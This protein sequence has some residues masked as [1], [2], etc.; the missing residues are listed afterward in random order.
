MT[1]ETTPR[2][3]NAVFEYLIAGDNDLRFNA[4]VNSIGSQRIAPH[5]EYPL[6]VHPA[7]YF[8][9]TTKGRVLHEW[10]LLYITQ[11]QGSFRAGNMPPVAIDK[12]TIV[13]LRPGELHSYWPSPQTGWVEYYIGF[14]GAAFDRMLRLLELDK[15]PQMWE[16][17]LNNELTRLYERAFEIASNKKI[18]PQPLLTG[19]VYHMLGLL[20]YSIRNRTD[21]PTADLL[22]Q[23]V[24]KAKIIMENKVAEEIDLHE[25]ASE[26]H[27]SYSWFRKTFKDYT[28]HAPA[29]YFQQLKLR[30][31]ERMLSETTLP[32]KEIAYSLGYKSTEHFFSL[33]KRNTGFTPTG[34][35]NYGREEV[36]TLPT[37]RYRD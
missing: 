27:L 35:R 15:G 24:E 23:A 12:G 7:D 25:L 21:K 14:A 28:G 30:R 20:N 36:P 2:R 4:V 13:L 8:F 11:G 32:I 33:F 26:L 5:S 1:D 31:A 3:S 22:E 17:G 34:Y 29:K 37:N 9:D 6:K 18:A 16:I 10:Q 19:I